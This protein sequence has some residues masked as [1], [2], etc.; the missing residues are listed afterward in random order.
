[1]IFCTAYAGDEKVKERIDKSGQE[2]LMKPVPPAVIREAV[3]HAMMA[4][5]S[6]ERATGTGS[7]GVTASA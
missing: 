4:A 1:M 2:L 5:T 3:Y 6:G 7:A